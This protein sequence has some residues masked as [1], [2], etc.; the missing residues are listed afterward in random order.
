MDAFMKEA[1]KEAMIAG[2]EGGFPIGG[3]LV[4]D[5]KIVGRG[6]DERIQKSNPILHGEL[7]AI[8]NIGWQTNEFYRDSILYTT[9]SP[10]ILCTGAILLCR[11]AKVVVGDSVNVPNEH[12]LLLARGVQ[13]E[14]QNDPEVIALLKNFIQEKP[15]V[16]RQAASG[17]FKHHN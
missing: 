13:V 2:Q 5:G 3:V 12:K 1:Y 14:V 4:R 16:W 17:T 8:A 11:L 6:H 10:C 7:N 9:I 15:E